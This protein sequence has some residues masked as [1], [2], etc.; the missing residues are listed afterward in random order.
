MLGPDDE[1][2]FDLWDRDESGD[3]AWEAAKLHR[4]TLHECRHTF[5]S[6]MIAAG[7]NTRRSRH[8]WA[9]RTSRSRS[10]ATAT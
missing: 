6:L 3:T 2:V 8:S 1:R 9:T 10:T 5:A 4:I 7:V